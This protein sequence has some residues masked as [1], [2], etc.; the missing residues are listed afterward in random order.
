[1]VWAAFWPPSFINVLG[2]TD[3]WER[4]WCRLKGLNFPTGLGILGDTQEKL[5]EVIM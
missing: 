1:M 2:M 3:L 5:E 4:P